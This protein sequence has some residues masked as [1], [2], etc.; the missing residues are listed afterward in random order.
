MK[1]KSVNSHEPARPEPDRTG[2]QTARWFESHLAAPPFRAYRDR[3]EAGQALVAALAKYEGQPDVLL[4]ALPR[5]GVPVAYEVANALALPLD[6]WLVR[7][8]G[9]PGHE[10]LAM[11]ALAVNGTLHINEDITAALKI[12]QRLINQVVARE[13]A[14]LSRRNKLYR[15]GKPLPP[16]RNKTVI[17]IDD[18][19]ATG[20]TMRAAL[21]SLRAAKPGH[22]IAAVPVGAESSCQMIGDYAD[23][24]I[25]LQK[26]E[27][28]YG[29]GQWYQDFSQTS[30]AQVKDMLHGHEQER[31]H[32]R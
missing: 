25:C 1:D 29:V 11:G 2:E 30:D 21:E 22:L 15:A 32:A 16:L 17:V 4:L 19:L 12:P 23:E 27:P 18:G 24:V 26:P 10:E 14:E 7:K 5:G 8:L 3:T 31:D 9:V 13:R 28:F 6:V 20:S